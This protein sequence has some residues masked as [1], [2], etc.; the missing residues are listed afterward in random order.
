MGYI[1]PHG[2]NADERLTAQQ[3]N[4]GTIHHDVDRSDGTHRQSRNIKF[5]HGLFE[6]DGNIYF[7]SATVNDTAVD[8][9]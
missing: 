1:R 2:Q 8:A 5:N 9:Y 4:H 7:K 3:G 6:H